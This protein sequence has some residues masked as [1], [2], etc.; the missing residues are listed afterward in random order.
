MSIED[1]LG[2]VLDTARDLFTGKKTLE[3]LAGEALGDKPKETT[4]PEEKPAARVTALRIV[5]TEDEGKCE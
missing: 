3:D 4:K 2:S 1:M 5:P